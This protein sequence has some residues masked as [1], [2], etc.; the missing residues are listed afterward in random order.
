[1]G[2]K[3]AIDDFGTGYSMLGYLAHFPFDHLKIDQRLAPNIPTN[4]KEVAIVSGVITI[5]QNLGLTVIAE[6][7]E[8]IEQVEF[9]QTMGLHDFQGWYF[10][11]EITV[12]EMTELLKN[13]S[14]W[15]DKTLLRE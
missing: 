3:L 8:T 10:S 5:G 13:D 1:M 14:P 6:G 4:A 15:E 11:R 12:D 7:V 9:Y 2:I